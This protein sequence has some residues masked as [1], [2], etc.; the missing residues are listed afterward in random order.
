MTEKDPCPLAIKRVVFQNFKAMKDFTL[1]LTSANILVGPNNAG[2]STILDSFRVLAAGLRGGRARPS[3]LLRRA[4]SPRICYSIPAEAIPTSLENVHTEYA[5]TDTTVEFHLSN[6]RTLTLLFPE[7]GGCYL[8]LDPELWRPLIPK[9]FRGRY[10]IDVSVVPVLGPV[11]HNELLLERQTVQR[12]LATRRASLHFRNFW[13]HFR[14]DFDVFAGLVRDTWPGMEIERP[15]PFFVEQKSALRMFCK[16]RRIARELY[17]AGFGF[18]VWC[19][20][21]TH[22]VRSRN[23]SVLV[24]DEPEIYLHPDVQRQLLTILKNVGPDILIATH[25]TEI[26]EAADPQDIVVIDKER[27]KARRLK[28]VADVQGAMELLGSAHNLTLSQLAR[29]Q[30][31]VFVEGQDAKLL[32]RLARGR[33]LTE[34]ASGT[35]LTFIPLGGFQPDKLKALAWGMEKVLGQALLL[36]VILDKDYRSDEEVQELSLELGD[37]YR[38]FH[39]HGRKELE[40]YLLSPA[41]IDRTISHLLR[42]R[43]RRDG[44]QPPVIPAA[45]LLLEQ[46]TA[47]MRAEVISQYMARYREFF[48][49]SRLDAATLMATA[50]ERCEAK[51]SVLD[52]RLEIVP[53]KQVFSALAKQV[54]EQFQLTITQRAVADH[55]QQRDLAPDFDRLLLTLD[56]FRTITPP[57]NGG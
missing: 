39:I 36:G 19:Q 27:R 40:N 17:W 23:T 57:S 53:G 11:D 5:E 49:R 46:V 9:E 25:S 31:V 2:K 42:D 56:K 32:L 30:R 12:A 24:I 28:S 50:M 10:S 41:A 43:A 1:W 29:N 20:L 4:G 16:E 7:D 6:S 33:G 44:Q 26:I 51:W 35:G 13:Y 15:E 34:L 8:L 18:Q 37:H 52:D 55:M 47:T 14:D 54:A 21:L 45:R 48:A 3:A 22:V 38:F